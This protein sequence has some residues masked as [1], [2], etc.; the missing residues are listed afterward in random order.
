MGT[1]SVAVS[2][3]THRAVAVRRRRALTVAGASAAAAAVWLVAWTVGTEP[4][5]TMGAQAPMVIGLPMV[6]PTALT[7]SLAAWGAVSVLERLTRHARL[8]W[9]AVALVALATSFLPVVAVRADGVTRLALA[10]MHVVVAA[11]LIPGLLPAR[12]PRRGREGSPS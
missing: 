7:V 5:V 10:A 4:T 3:P 11:V 12:G 6:V 2:T 9:P 1:S 8:L